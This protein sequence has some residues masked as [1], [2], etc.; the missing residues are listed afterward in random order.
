MDKNLK[1]RCVSLAA[2]MEVLSI[3]SSKFYTKFNLDEITALCEQ[4]RHNII[5]SLIKHQIGF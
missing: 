4:K 3:I 2:S 5:Y 1:Y